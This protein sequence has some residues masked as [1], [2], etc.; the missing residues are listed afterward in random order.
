MPLYLIP[1]DA[2]RLRVL[3]FVSE[4]LG[5]ITSLQLRFEE[6]SG[7]LIHVLHHVRAEIHVVPT[8]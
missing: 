4:T 2:A 7:R 6:V 1:R 8:L 5:L 3:G